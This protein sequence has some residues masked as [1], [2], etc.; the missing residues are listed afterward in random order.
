[1]TR[2]VR[3]LGRGGALA[4]AA[5]GL[6]L[7]ASGD[8]ADA[9]RLSTPGQLS[10]WAF[11]EYATVARA[12]PSPKA[13]P[14]GRLKLRTEDRTDELTLAVEERRGWVRVRLPQRPNGRTGWVRRWTLGPWHTTRDWV[15]VDK[16]RLRLTLVRDGTAIFSAPIGIGGRGTPT[17]A[18]EFYVR[19]RLVLDSPTGL[20]GPLAFGTSARSPTLTDWPRGGVVG[21]HGTNQPGLVPGRPSHGCIRLRNADILELGELLEVGTPVTIRS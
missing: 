15:R 5:C 21:I 4:A 10:R 19:N 14:V 9:K 13:R 6:V 7:L 20:Y 12:K 8:R 16:R 3:T 18:G 1:V 11:V 17:P 2:A